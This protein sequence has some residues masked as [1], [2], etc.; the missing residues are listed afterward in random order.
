MEAVSVLTTNPINYIWLLLISGFG[1]FIFIALILARYLIK[2]LGFDRRHFNH[3]IFSIR[4][5]KEKPEDGGKET[6]LQQLKEEIAKGETIFSSIGGLR[7]ER[8]F[9][10]WLLGRSDHFCF[11]IVAEH[12]KIY[13]YVVAPVAQA[14]YL[15][16]Q[17]NAHYPEAVIEEV[18]DYNAFS[19][20][21]QVAAGYLKTKNPFMLFAKMVLWICLIIFCLN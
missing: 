6:S 2:A 1:V 3:K 8:G 9:M 17:I 7:A 12:G 5:P 16:K 21:A 10:S 11:E 13:F 20:L 18:D 4:L 15:E 19:P 14:L